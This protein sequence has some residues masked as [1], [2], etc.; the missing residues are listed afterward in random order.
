MP[1]T[2]LLVVSDKEEEK[3]NIFNFIGEQILEAINKIT[4]GALNPIEQ[5]VMAPIKAI[6]GQVTQ[7]GVWKGNGANRFVE[8][9]NGK[10]LPGLSNLHQSGQQY[11]G[12]I[13][14][15]FDHMVQAAQQA[16][17]MVGAMEDAFSNICNF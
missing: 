13:Q 12:G 4:G 8:D 3:M 17:N 14:K 9:L 11:T 7:G 15:S 2:R 1:T 16:T 5:M 6:I 10:V